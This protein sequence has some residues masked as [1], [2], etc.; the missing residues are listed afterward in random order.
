MERVGTAVAGDQRFGSATGQGL[1]RL[2]AGALRR[3]QA[4]LVGENFELLRFRVI[5]DELRRPSEAGVYHGIQ[6]VP[7][8]TDDDFHLV[9]TSWKRFSR[10]RTAVP[11]W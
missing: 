10:R 3:V 8:G 2:D 6:R 7:L 4:L 9:T 1:G 5:E 11:H